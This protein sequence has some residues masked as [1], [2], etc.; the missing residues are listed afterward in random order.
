MFAVFCEVGTDVY[1]FKNILAILRKI[2]ET[3]DTFHAKICP[4]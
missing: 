2:V 3:K 1:I 4:Y